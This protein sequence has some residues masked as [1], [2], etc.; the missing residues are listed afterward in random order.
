MAFKRDIEERLT[1]WKNSDGRKPLI[2][3]G[4]R[5]VGKTT[6]VKDF[7]SVYKYTIFLNLEKPADRRFFEDFNDVHTIMEALLLAHG[8]PSED[9][10]HTLLFI[11]EIQESPKA[12]QLLRY[13]YEELP[14]L[15]V[16]SAGSLLEFALHRVQSFP[17][18]RVEFLYLHP[19]SF[20]EYLKAIAK[21][22]WREA[23]Q[24]L[25]LNPAAHTVLMEAFHRYAIIGGMPEVIKVDRENRQLSDLVGVYESIWG[26]YKNDVEKYTSNDTERKIIKHLMDS[27]PLYVDERI[28]F[29]GFGNS[30]YRSR[31][32]GEAFRTLD[33][34]R[35]VRMIYPTTDLSP[36]L[37]PDIKKSPRLQ[38]LDTGLINYTLGIQGELLGMTDLSSAYRGAIIP[39]LVTQEL[40][41]LQ[42]Q[43]DNK[44]LFWV[45]QKPQSSAEVDLLFVYQRFVIPIEIKSGATGSLKSLHQYIEAADHPF[46][47]RIYGGEFRLEKAITPGGKPYFLLNVPYY[48][49]TRIPHYAAWLVQSAAIG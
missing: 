7:A 42:Q 48:A 5:Q 35:I 31:E 41:S 22:Q 46:A 12:I 47:I 28:R 14:R 23:L 37:R 33:A 27:A 44:P 20:P 3:R 25:P 8:I 9:M 21:P 49:A 19:L 11:D 2:I 29:Q 36:P 17:V 38:F 1:A 13:F 26:T 6:L 4:A 15:H 34:A 30:N 43:T 40:I 10:G 16:I 39:H 24:Q 32:V 45:R 18:G